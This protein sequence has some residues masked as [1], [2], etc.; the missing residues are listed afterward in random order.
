M[1][2]ESNKNALRMLKGLQKTWYNH[3]FQFIPDV[4][5]SSAEPWDN[6]EIKEIREMV[7]GLKEY[8]RTLEEWESELI[9]LLET[10]IK[11]VEALIKKEE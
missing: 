5:R 8:A 3:K 7:L 9:N 6:S 2:L 1:A 4:L 10:Q 11:K